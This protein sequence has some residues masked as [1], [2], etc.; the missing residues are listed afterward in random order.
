MDYPTQLT[1]PLDEQQFIRIVRIYALEHYE[2]GGWDEVAEA[3]DD[4]DI[5]EYYQTDCLEAFKQLALTV[6][7]RHEYAQEI[8]LTA[9]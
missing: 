4:G 5:L 2:S 9:F 7:L 6:Q 1:Q 3:W 8:R